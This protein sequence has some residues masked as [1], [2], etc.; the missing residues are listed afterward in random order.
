MK[1]LELQTVAEIVSNNFHTSKIFETYDIDFCCQGN[2]SLNEI[3]QKKGLD[4]GIIIQELT[5]LNNNFE[6]KETDYN[7]WSLD[8]L[9]QHI[10]N[11]HH[12][13]IESQTP[14]IIKYL[15]KI[16]QVHGK[17]H[18]ELFNIQELFIQSAS[19]L[20]QHMKK[21]ELIL[22]PYIQKMKFSLNNNQ[23]FEAAPFGTIQK[24]I[25]MMQHEH[26][27]EGDI[28]KEIARL[29]SN[30]SPPSDACNSYIITYN[31]LKEFELDL[32]LHIHLENNIL[33]PKAVKLET[34]LFY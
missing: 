14:L 26:N 32:H 29:S 13:F 7:N 9:S 28:F 17:L 25:Q 2:I 22:F 5:T 30:Y 15:E 20:S 8:I 18:P 33:F 19:E 27:T 31:L 1:N 4:K 3:C 24:P 11:K 12:K 10:E 34:E 16:C 6:N 23:P 21:E